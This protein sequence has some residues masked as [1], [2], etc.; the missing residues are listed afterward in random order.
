MP[1][2]HHGNLR[3]TLL[4]AAERSLRQH[5]AEQLSL[6][7]LA[8][9]VGVSHAAPRRHFPDR[10]ALLDAL[11]E[12]GFARLHAELRAAQDAAG[13]EFGPRL[14]AVAAAY[15]RFATEDAALL[16]L[17]F[18]GKHRADAA[19][20]VAAAAAPFGLLDRLIR[21]GQAAGV[22]E[23]GDSQRA[24]IVLFATLQGIATLVN[25]NLV[26][27]DMLDGI[28]TTAVDQFMRGSR[29]R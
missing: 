12:A 8:R 27:P 21:Q 25:G 22:L 18:A 10:Q 16:A 4:A 15:L 23:P 17:M 28:V 3:T 24:G 2:Y 11:A 14:H 26:P 20:L 6:R 5:G 29:R 13:E 7:E 19:Q 9:E 1:A